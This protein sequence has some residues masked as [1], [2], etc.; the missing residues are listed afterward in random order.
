MGIGES[1]PLEMAIARCHINPQKLAA[2]YSEQALF[3]ASALVV[4]APVVVL[5]LLVLVV[6]YYHTIIRCEE[7]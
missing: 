4:V 1:G 5:L 3:D 2:K 7:E 6:L